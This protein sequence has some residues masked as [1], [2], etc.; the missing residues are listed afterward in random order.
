MF[1]VVMMLWQYKMYFLSKLSA[2]EELELDTL[3]EKLTK[4]REDEQMDGL[5]TESKR[6]GMMRMIFLL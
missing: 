1:Y 4:M 3:A 6:S 5:W 2:S